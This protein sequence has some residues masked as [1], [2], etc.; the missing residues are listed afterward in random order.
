VRRGDVIGR[1]GNSGNTTGPHLH[2]HVGDRVTFEDAEGLPYRFRDV[3]VL[4]ETS[5]E[6]ALDLD[7]AAAAFD[8]AGPRRRG[9]PL[10]GAVVHFGLPIDRP[11]SG[12]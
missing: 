8:A 7:E 4:G 10:H 12:R 1:V 9:L 3:H 6:R 5:A 11:R 2:L